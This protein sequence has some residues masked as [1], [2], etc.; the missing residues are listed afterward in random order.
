MKTGAFKQGEL[1][2]LGFGTS[3]VNHRLI[4]R[5]GSFNVKRS[6][7]SRLNLTDMY[8]VLIS[9]PSKRF[10]AII[11]AGY[12]FINIFFACIYY[13]T[14]MQNLEGISDTGNK[15]LFLDALAFSGQ[16]FT[17]L[18]Y[19]RIS[20][21]GFWTNT[22]AV[23]ES[24][25]GLMF[26]AIVTG[27]LYGRFSRPVAR[28]V[29]SNSAIIAP[30]HGLT[31]FEFR[32]ANQ[33]RN[34]LIEVD[35]EVMLTVIDS[36]TNTRRFEELSLERSKVDFLPLSWTIVHPIEQ[37]SPLYGMSAEDMKNRRVEFIILIKAF[38]DT[39]SQSIYS[40][41]SYI[42]DEIV[43]GKTFGSM[44]ETAPGGITNFDL[45]RLHDV[46]EVVVM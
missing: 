45:R 5:N 36:A 42:A 31:A 4:N 33:R 22:I 25:I 28:I 26:F 15:A 40:R 1:R 43:W 7:F 32:I 39:Y 41:S 46:K 2:D 35:V 30:Y 17:T 24:A 34:Q 27:F 29:F 16:T 14:G 8:D 13:F 10:V 19:G 6:G 23:T 21:L 44:Y 18:G 3:G 11:L 20:P 9:M 37:N 38:D 12:V